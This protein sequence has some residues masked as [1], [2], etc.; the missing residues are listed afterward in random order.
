MATSHCFCRVAFSAL[1][2]KVRIRLSKWLRAGVVHWV[3]MKQLCISHVQLHIVMW[4]CIWARASLRHCGPDHEQVWG[5][6]LPHHT[7]K[8]LSTSQLCCWWPS[9]DLVALLHVTA[10][11]QRNIL[12][13]LTQFSC[14][15]PR[16][17][18]YWLSPSLSCMTTWQNLVLSL[19]QFLS[20]CPDSS[21]ICQVR[22]SVRQ[23][24]SKK[25]MRL[26]GLG[27]VD[28][29]TMAPAKQLF[30]LL[31]AGVRGHDEQVWL[32]RDWSCKRSSDFKL[33]MQDV[34]KQ[35][36]QIQIAMNDAS[37]ALLGTP[38]S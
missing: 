24:Q 13:S 35:C 4:T 26:P 21:W 11:H 25:Q 15:F 20:S 32:I 1:W 9:K 6:R 18:S 36:M 5:I 19:L 34:T 7:A 10:H 8:L 37:Q 22:Q 38:P 12:H 16:T 33:T 2:C 14:R 3:Q 28:N 31:V 17:W 27:S 23:R 30:C 29:K